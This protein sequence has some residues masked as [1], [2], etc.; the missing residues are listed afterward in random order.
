M[1]M[2][3]IAIGNH[4]TLERC[5]PE[6]L[7]ETGIGCLSYQEVLLAVRK[8]LGSSFLQGWSRGFCLGSAQEIYV[9]LYGLKIL[10]E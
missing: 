5:P 10:I 8:S 3:P 2:A 9:Q 4:A 7:T 6:Q 1:L